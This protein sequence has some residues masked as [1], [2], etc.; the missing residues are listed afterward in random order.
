MKVEAVNVADYAN[1]PLEKAAPSVAKFTLLGGVLGAFLAAG[2]IAVLFLMDDTI[3]TPDDVEK[4]LKLSTLG[5]IP[6]DEESAAEEVM[7]KKNRKK[8]K[9]SSKQSKK[10]TK[11]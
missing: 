6:F 11:K 9:K 1:L 5:S 10:S 3:K 7:N 4:Y 8:Y 2:I